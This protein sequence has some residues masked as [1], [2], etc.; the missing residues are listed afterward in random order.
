MSAVGAGFHGLGK[1]LRSPLLVLWLWIVSVVVALPAAALMA[2]SLE[3]S[4]GGSL[5]YE[6]LRD[7]FDMGWYGEFRSSAEGIE[8]TF[9]PTV[10]GIGPF[11]DN[12]EAWLN[13]SLFE[14]HPGL[15]G[16]GLLYAALWALLL[17]GILHRLSNGHGLFRLGDFFSRGGEFFFRYLRLAVIGG[18]LYYLVYRFASWLFVW[19]EAQSRDVTVEETVLGYVVAGSLLVGFLLTFVNMAF[20]YAKI[21]T[22]KENRRSML[23]AAVRGFGFVLSHPG[24][25]MVL[26]YGL[27]LVALVLLWAYSVVAPGTGQATLPGIAIAFLI[28]QAYL[29]AKLVLRLTFYSSQMALYESASRL[30]S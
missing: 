27:A 21:A 8:K 14:T 12:A 22:F 30:A 3:D 20:D 11:L 6:K 25:T 9:T 18:V 13:G 28:G 10:V 4:I 5:V 17:G 26:Y 2:R 24:S 29:V 7:G 16:L 1:V 15:L 19:I 23:L